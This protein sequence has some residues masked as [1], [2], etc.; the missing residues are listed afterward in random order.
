M[1]L[2]LGNKNNGKRE[3]SIVRGTMLMKK[4]LSVQFTQRGSQSTAVAWENYIT[5]NCYS[6]TPLVLSPAHL[7]HGVMRQAGHA[8]LPFS[9]M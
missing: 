9:F 4:G 2:V 3:A 6:V 8:S 7:F 5:L 1:L